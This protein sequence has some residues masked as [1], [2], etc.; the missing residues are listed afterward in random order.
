MT[1]TDELKE[2]DPVFGVELREVALRLVAVGEQV[3]TDVVGAVLTQRA[4]VD[5][6][7]TR[8]GEAVAA[9][10][11]GVRARREPPVARIAYWRLEGGG[12][13]R[14]HLGY[15]DLVAAVEDQAV[16]DAAGDLADV[17]RAVMHPDQDPLVG[18]HR[19]HDPQDQFVGRVT[20][21]GRQRSRA[22]RVAGRR[23]SPR[24]RGRAAQR[25]L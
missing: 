13:D 2:R 21:R 24:S 1:D 14:A 12:G 18:A 22:G 25:P 15:R 8:F 23:R 4:E 19:P 7:V 16:G 17:L 9:V 20:G 3:V 11:D 10:A 5:G 6:V